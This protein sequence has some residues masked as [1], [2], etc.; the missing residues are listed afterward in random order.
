MLEF[1][2]QFTVVVMA[3]VLEVSR[4]GFYAW[5]K[6]RGPSARAR[7]REALDTRVKAAFTAAKGRSGAP[8]L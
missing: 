7:A 8:R 5:R 2:G 4:S 3:R 6:G 1:L